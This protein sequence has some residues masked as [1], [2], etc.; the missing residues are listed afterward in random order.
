[1][2]QKIDSSRNPARI[3][4]FAMRQLSVAKR[5]CGSWLCRKPG[6]RR[7]KVVEIGEARSFSG[8]IYA[9]IAATSGRT[10]MMFMTRVRL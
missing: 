5:R 4:P 10:P 6:E 1:M 9:V 8:L 7:R 3:K 2:C